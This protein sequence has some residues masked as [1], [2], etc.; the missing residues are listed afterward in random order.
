MP[1][2]PPLLLDTHVWI[3]LVEGVEHEMTP[4]AIQ[5]LREASRDGRLLVSHISVWEVAML[6]G[7]GRLQLRVD[8]DS[9]IERAL[10][11]PGVSAVELS[12]DILI[13]SARLP[14]EVHGDPADRIIMAAARR[15]GATVATRDRAMAGYA[16]EG[17]LAVLDVAA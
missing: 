9:W 11:A 10:A 7:K 1:E 2:P 5:V 4:G 13:E 15:A 14:G 16:A 6:V 17:H 12:P 8:I 3:W